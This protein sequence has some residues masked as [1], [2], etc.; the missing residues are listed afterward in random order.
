MSCD[1]FSR[2]LCDHINKYN[3]VD[4]YNNILQ[5]CVLSTRVCCSNV[6]GH[7]C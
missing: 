4:E 2:M 7:M 1:M 3:N 6:W 5:Y